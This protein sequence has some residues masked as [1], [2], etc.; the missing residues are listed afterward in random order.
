MK[1]TLLVTA[2]A[3]AT[4]FPAVASDAISGGFW[5]NHA[6]YDGDVDEATYGDTNYEALVLYIDKTDAASGWMFSSEMR[7]GKGAFTD[8]DNNN[9][10]SHF[11]FHKA[12]VGKEFGNGQVKI[13]KSAVPFGFGTMNFWPGDELLGG[14]GDQMDVG[15]K[16]TATEGALTYDVAYFHVD[17]FGN[18][19]ET[20]DDDK[21]WGEVATYQKSQTFVGNVAYEFSQGQTV[22]ASY[23]NGRLRDLSD[24]DD[25]RPYDGNHNAAIVYY[26]GEFGPVG[27]KAQYITTYRDLRGVAQGVTNDD[28]D[29][30]VPQDEIKN[31]RRGLTVSYA[32]DDFNF[33]VDYT[34]AE[35]N[36]KGHKDSVGS[37][38]SFAPGMS[39][40][41]GPGWFYVEYVT[42]D[43]TID[44]NGQL[45]NADEDYWYFTMDYYF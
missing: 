8:P 21:H 20:M 27:V 10:G 35:S 23:Q 45:Q 31:D 22:G 4:A 29:I 17:D 6:I 18:S 43:G 3:A 19:T 25:A 11:G 14:F 5:L 32:M 7:Y 15:V 13:G 40:D 41:Y 28:G 37:A 9:T 38:D 44:R 24:A 1:K 42:N 34:N 2:M 39:Y 33:Y 16:W 12:W 30:L 36:T 26:S